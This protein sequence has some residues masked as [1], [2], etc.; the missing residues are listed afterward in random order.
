MLLA[1]VN[2]IFCWQNK[3]FL[4]GYLFSSS[5]IFMWGILCHF[6]HSLWSGVYTCFFTI[7]STVFLQSPLDCC[8]PPIFTCPP[9]QIMYL[10]SPAPFD[11]VT[12]DCSH[13]LLPVVSTPKSSLLLSST[14]YYFIFVFLF[15][16]VFYRPP[17]TPNHCQLS[18]SPNRLLH[19]YIIG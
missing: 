11:A 18:L 2:M 8:P 14:L 12:L 15:L 6:P 9:P 13:I 1:T 5:F 3:P 10:P 4:Y 16:P 7:M 19:S 17:L